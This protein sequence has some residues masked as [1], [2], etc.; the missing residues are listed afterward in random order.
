M[1]VYVNIYAFSIF[2]AVFNCMENGIGIRNDKKAFS[3]YFSSVAY[4]HCY[5]MLEICINSCNKQNKN[6]SKYFYVL[7]INF[8]KS[9]V[10]LV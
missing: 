5:S 7:K 1:T 4:I 9:I 3:T 6:K 2:I 8:L 10:L